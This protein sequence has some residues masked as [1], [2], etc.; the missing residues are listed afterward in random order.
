M[1]LKNIFKK[2]LVIINVISS[3]GQVLLI[4]LIYFFL[5]RLLLNYLGVELLGV[6][7]IVLSTSSLANLAN[8]GVADSVIRFVALFSKDGENNKLHELI[9]TAS[10]FLIGIFLFIAMVIYPFANLILKTVLPFKFV[11]EG[12]LI[13]PYSL[14]CLIIN[15]VNG[16]FASVLDGMQKNYIRTLIFSTSSVF[17]LIMAYILVPKFNLLGVAYAQVIQSLFTLIICFIAVIIK[18]NYNPVKWHW[19]SGIFKQIFG[20]GIKFQ[21][22]SLAAMLND[23]ITKILLGRFGGMA[24]VGYY[25]MANR[26]INQVRGIIVNGTQS[27]VPV[28]VNLQNEISEIQLFYLKL[29][30]NVL[31]FTLS[32]VSIITISGRLISFYWIGQF[33]PFFYFSLIILSISTFLNLISGPAYFFNMAQGNLKILIKQHLILGVANVVFAYFLGYF[34]NGI[35]VLLGWLTA[36]LLGSIF[37]LNDFNHK[38]LL[39]YNALIRLKDFIFFMMIFFIT[40]ISYLI[41]LEVHSKMLDFIFLLIIF[42]LIVSY[43]LKYKINDIFKL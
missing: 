9:F 38:Y 5:Y 26:L 24:F 17:L 36:I 18:T 16:V 28:M 10:V 19:N 20:Y 33:Q 2:H 34:F 32:L 37:L 35:G 21:F 11:K 31:F 22:I 29:F 40:I 41:Q 1:G 23:P 43:F 14:L 7:S 39:K 6:W 27:L 13:L 3:G 25:E 42:S 15:G 8:F 12:L 30:S 4:G